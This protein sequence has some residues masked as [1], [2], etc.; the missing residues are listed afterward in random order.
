VADGATDRSIASRMG[1]SATAVRYIRTG[2]TKQLHAHT[3]L[4]IAELLEGVNHA[5]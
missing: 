2:V 1:Y 3:A 4:A 5:H